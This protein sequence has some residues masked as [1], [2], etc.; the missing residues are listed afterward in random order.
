MKSSKKSLISFLTLSM[1]LF[2]IIS[3]TPEVLAVESGK[4]NIEVEIRPTSVTGSSIAI[5]VGGALVTYVIAE[6][7]D[8]IIASVTGTDGLSDYVKQQVDALVGQP[9]RSSLFLSGSSDGSGGDGG[10]GGFSIFEQQY[11]NNCI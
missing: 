7:A 1:T 11:L 5:Y 4:D 6:V 8:G 9:Y 10:S 2:S 3:Q